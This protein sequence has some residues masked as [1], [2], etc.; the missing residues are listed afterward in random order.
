MRETVGN[1]DAGAREGLSAPK[2]GSRESRAKN[3]E[4]GKESVM[5]KKISVVGVLKAFF[6]PPKLTMDELKSCPPETRHELATMAA[7]AMG[8]EPAGDGKTWFIEVW[9][10]LSV[11][12]PVP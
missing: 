1:A 8:L 7:E 11:D 5:A 12:L 4:R 6:E 9:P 3:G 2:D 10:A